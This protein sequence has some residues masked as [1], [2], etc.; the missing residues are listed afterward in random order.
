MINPEAKDFDADLERAIDFQHGLVVTSITREE[1]LAALEAMRELIARR[2]AERVE[3][4]ER[5]QGLR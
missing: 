4:M 3:Q 1:K 5:E 2:S